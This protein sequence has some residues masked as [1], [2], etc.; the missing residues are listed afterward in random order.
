MLI[1]TEESFC[2]NL[3]IAAP[4]S[5]LDRCNIEKVIGLFREHVVGIVRR[6]QNLEKDMGE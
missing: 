5:D 4:L 2:S 1:V 6:D 3:G